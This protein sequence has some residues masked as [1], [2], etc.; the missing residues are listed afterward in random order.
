[1]YHMNETLDHSVLLRIWFFYMVAQ[2]CKRFLFTYQ[3]IDSYAIEV[4]ESPEMCAT[5]HL[6][7]TAALTKSVN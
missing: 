7:D 1:M 3:S 5:F 6:H 2:N 4:R